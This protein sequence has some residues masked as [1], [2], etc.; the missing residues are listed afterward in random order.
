VCVFTPGVFFIWTGFYCPEGTEEPLSCPANTI[1]ETPG[2]SAIHNCLLCPP[3]QW[4]L[5]GMSVAKC[6]VN[7][8]FIYLYKVVLHVLLHPLE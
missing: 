8:V 1:R 2:A 7:T 4:C 6:C 3:R 5:E